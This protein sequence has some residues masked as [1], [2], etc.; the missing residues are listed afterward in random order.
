L[1]HVPRLFACY[2]LYRIS[3]LCPDQLGSDHPIYPSYVAGIKVHTTMPSLLLIEIES[4]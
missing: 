3:P 2:F 4:P 1:R